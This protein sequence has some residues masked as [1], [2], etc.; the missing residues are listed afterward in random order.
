MEESIGL[1]ELQQL[2][3]EHTTNNTN[4]KSTQDSSD[5]SQLPYNN[6]T[7]ERDITLETFY[8]H[9]EAAELTN[10]VT[11][12]L[13]EI[14]P[15]ITHNFNNKR[16]TIESEEEAANAALAWYHQIRTKKATENVVTALENAEKTPT[17]TIQ[18]LVNDSV[19]NALNK[20]SN[21]LVKTVEKQ[22]RKKSSGLPRNQDWQ[23]EIGRAHV[24]SS[25][26]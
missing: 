5:T 25:H 26:P 17:K 13:T 15:T 16:K 8:L 1:D 18:E 14:L 23:A 4:I 6:N 12:K 7:Y 21:Q 20:T 11:N 19:S 3:K 22:L 9:P 2:L 10:H 24:N